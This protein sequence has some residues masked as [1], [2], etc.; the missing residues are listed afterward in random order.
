MLALEEPKAEYHSEALFREACE[1]KVAVHERIYDGE[2][3]FISFPFHDVTVLYNVGFPNPP[4]LLYICLSELTR[5]LTV[6]DGVLPDGGHNRT[7]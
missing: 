4:M 6:E 5:F 2:E 7:I 3:T 1:V